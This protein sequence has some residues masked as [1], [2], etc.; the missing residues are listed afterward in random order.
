MKTHRGWISAFT[1][2]VALAACAPS[3][4]GSEPAASVEPSVA[5]V[6][7][8]SPSEQVEGF[9]TA[10]FA[11]IRED[12][13]SEEAAAEF[14]AI[15]DDMAGRA[16]MAATVMTAEGTWSGATG[17]ANDVRDVRVDDQFAIASVTKSVVAAQVMQLVEAGELECAVSIDRPP[18]RL[19]NLAEHAARLTPRTRDPPP[20]AFPSFFLP[21]TTRRPNIF[22]R[23][24][25]STRTARR[26]VNS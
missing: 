10:A 21:S 15:L 23:T 3:S 7:S 19:G 26:S 9:P 12:P 24:S 13:V 25:T 16:G 18:L 5:P 11:D 6:A 22:R 2:V 1:L 14:Q 8:A 17:K 4:G 20:P